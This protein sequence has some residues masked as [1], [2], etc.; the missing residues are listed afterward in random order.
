MIFN[1]NVHVEL[2]LVGTSCRPELRGEN[3]LNSQVLS[4][5]AMSEKKSDPANLLSLLH[6]HGSCV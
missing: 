4:A 5:C 3:S 6:G 2:M 1:K